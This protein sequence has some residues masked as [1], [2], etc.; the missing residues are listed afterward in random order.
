M[1][2]FDS[3]E[4][5]AAII[6]AIVGGFIAALTQWFFAWSQRKYQERALATS[7]LLKLGKLTATLIVTKQH[8]DACFAEAGDVGAD[9]QPWQILTPIANLANPI[10]FTSDELSLLLAQANDNIFGLVLGM[11]DRHNDIIS[12]MHS[13]QEKR[14]DITRKLEPHRIVER[15]VGDRVDVLYPPQLMRDLSPYI[16]DL[17]SIVDHVR[18]HLPRDADTART[19]TERAQTLLKNRL[20]LKFRLQ[21]ND[22]SANN[23]P[24]L[25][26]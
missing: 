19:A 16:I 4:F 22:P 1:D 2:I 12:I 3:K 7:L 15:V 13:F 23:P 8:V 21:V 14:D 24:S 18:T 5:W 11:D 26:T 20:K 25:G 9:T 10:H 17:N 6:G